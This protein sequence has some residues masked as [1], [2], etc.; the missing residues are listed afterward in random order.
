MADGKI[1]LQVVR[2]D[3]DSVK[4]GIEAPATVPVHREEIEVAIREGRK[5]KGS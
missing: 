3:K 1:V 2:I 5:Q 4:F